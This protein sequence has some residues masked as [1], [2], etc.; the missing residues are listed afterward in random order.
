MTV[1]QEIHGHS[2]AY[3]TIVYGMEN[4]NQHERRTNIIANFPQPLSGPRQLDIISLWFL[5]G[6]KSRGS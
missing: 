6:I 5:F 4:M 3:T 2:F 1:F